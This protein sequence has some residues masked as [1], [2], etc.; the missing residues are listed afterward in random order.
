MSRPRFRSRTF[1]RVKVRVPGNKSRIHYEPRK[2]GVARCASCG[3]PLT[4]ASGSSAQIK[5]MPKTAKRAERL[6]SNLCPE[7]MRE[8]IKKQFRS[9]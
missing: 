1:K 2:K 6:Y 7:C 8:Q 5:R 9:Q 4:R 3:R